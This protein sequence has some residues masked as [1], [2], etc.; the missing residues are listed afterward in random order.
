MSNYRRGVLIVLSAGLIACDEH[1]AFHT[2][3]KVDI[4]QATIAPTTVELVVSGAMVIGPDGQRVIPAQ[5]GTLLPAATHKV[6]LKVCK[7]SPHATVTQTLQTLQAGKVSVTVSG[8]DPVRC[9]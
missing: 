1:S 2:T 5:S 3:A 8:A 4:P 7:G 6:A 9:G